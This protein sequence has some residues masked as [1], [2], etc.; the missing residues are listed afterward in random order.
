[1][2]EHLSRPGRSYREHREVFFSLPGVVDEDHGE[3]LELWRSYLQNMVKGNYRRN[4]PRNPFWS[5]IGIHPSDF[6]WEGFRSAMG[7]RNRR[8]A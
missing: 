3:Q 8:A 4:D 5:D 6:D 2:E 1:M 7:Y